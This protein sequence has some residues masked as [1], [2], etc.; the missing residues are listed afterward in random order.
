[1]VFKDFLS[2]EDIGG[3]KAGEKFAFRELKQVFESRSKIAFEKDARCCTPLDESRNELFKSG[4]I[5]GLEL[6]HR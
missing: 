1:M 6:L 2:P 3:I 4:P 5:E